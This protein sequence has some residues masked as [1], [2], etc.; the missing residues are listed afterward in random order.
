VLRLENRLRE[1]VA[2]GRA[3][4]VEGVA[5]ALRRQPFVLTLEQGKIVQ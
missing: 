5:S 1:A 4:T 3:V 2:V